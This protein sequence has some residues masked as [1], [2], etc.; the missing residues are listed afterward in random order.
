MDHAVPDVRVALGGEAGTLA[1]GSLRAVTV[2]LGLDQT[3]SLTLR[4]SGP[5][6]PRC[7]PGE[8]V[9]V[10]LGFG[11]HLVSVFSGEV[12][13]CGTELDEGGVSR[14]VR[15]LADAHRAFRRRVPE[16]ISVGGRERT[17]LGETDGAWTRA[18]AR[19]GAPLVVRTLQPGPE[20]EPDGR[21]G[22]TLRLGG[23][24]LGFEARA[25]FTSTPARVDVR[26][27]DEL[28]REAVIASAGPGSE[29][30]GTRPA[31]P[32]PFAGPRFLLREGLD[33][34]A[35][36][37]ALADAAFARAAE[38][39]VIAAARLRGRPDLAP[40][41][42]VTLAKLGAPLDGPWRVRAATH[43]WVPTG[44]ETRV[45]LTRSGWR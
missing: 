3:D 4:L 25:D 13:A 39:T 15:G 22:V 32:A 5:A 35:D 24:L 28:R 30:P 37:Q 44:F 17:R 7:A 38:R 45:E 42:R 20:H 12:T 29:W 41:D 36:A 1:R 16:R 10:H 26:G 19:N 6:E 8:P 33:A 9:T 43:L 40:G 31:V 11:G 27:W 18:A 23:D 21:A 14:T 2:R 34:R